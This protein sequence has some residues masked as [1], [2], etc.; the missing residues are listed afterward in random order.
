MKELS[1][2]DLKAFKGSLQAGYGF[3]KACH[4]IFRSVAEMSAL[5]NSNED[6]KELCLT[7]LKFHIR[8]LLA[9]G[10]KHLQEMDFDQFVKQ[11]GFMTRF[12]GKLTLWEEF[13]TSN[14]LNREKFIKAVYVYKYP[15]EVATA[16][17]LTIDKMYDFIYAD[18]TLYNYMFKIR[19]IT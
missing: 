5:V 19:F 7:C 18:D 8:A 10:Q 6:F 12:V 15:E 4:F 1:D 16:C 9:I 2:V 17:G 14:E 11:N 13:S 3:T